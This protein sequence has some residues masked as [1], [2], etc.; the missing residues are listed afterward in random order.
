MDKKFAGNEDQRFVHQDGEHLAARRALGQSEEKEH[1]TREE[2]IANLQRLT[3]EIV[4][5][6]DNAK[7]GK[8]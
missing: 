6:V 2:R 1:W 8:R 3:R 5:A 7:V 4:A